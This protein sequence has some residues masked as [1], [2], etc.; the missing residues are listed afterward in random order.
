MQTSVDRAHATAK[1]SLERRGVPEP[2]LEAS[3]LLAAVV[4]R[5]RPW[6]IAHSDSA[7]SAVACTRYFA[8][9]ERRCRRE[10]TAYLVGAKGW[11]DITLL[12]NRNVLIPRPETELLAE[13]AQAA[14]HQLEAASTRVPVAVDVGTGSGAL[15]IAM[16]RSSPRARV[17]GIDSSDAALRVAR[18]NAEQLGTRVQLERGNLLEQL[19]VVPDLVVANLP[20]IPTGAIDGL[21][22]E[23]AYEPLSALDGGPDG[24][25]VIRALVRQAKERLQPPSA[26]MLECGQHQARTVAMTLREHW[27]DAQIRIKPDLAGIDRI[28]VAQIR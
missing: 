26:I 28:V 25:D 27:P 21:E 20:Y 16:A 23:I 4:D 5:P 11:L 10:P 15:A 19:P 12:V 3:V 1:E 24:M 22:P 7:I 2:S 17:V 18:A 13:E 14:L 9:V 6:L 8:L